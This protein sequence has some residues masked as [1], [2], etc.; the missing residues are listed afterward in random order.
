MPQFEKAE[1]AVQNTEVFETLKT[2]IVNA[3]TNGSERFL[4]GA[5]SR[6]INARQFEQMLDAGLLDGQ[7][8][9]KELYAQLA[10]SDQG[11]IRELYL[12]QVEEVE[13]GL[14]RKYSKVY[15]YA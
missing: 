9:G 3:L 15:R 11:L 12:T 14:R 7:A 13:P 4:S 6:G 8:R 2:Q 10:L 5:A 1:I